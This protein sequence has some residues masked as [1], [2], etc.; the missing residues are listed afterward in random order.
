VANKFTDE[1]GMPVLIDE[2]LDFS[3]SGIDAL[4]TRGAARFLLCLDLDTK[5]FEEGIAA[6]RRRPRHL[7]ALVR[8]APS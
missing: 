6:A 2:T 3:E 1:D 7:R 4:L 5:F 8:R